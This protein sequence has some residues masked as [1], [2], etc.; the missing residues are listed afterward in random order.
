MPACAGGF[1]SRCS[2]EVGRVGA[3]SEG[4]VL[5][6]ELTDLLMRAWS[7]YAAVR[8]RGKGRFN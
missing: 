6:H 7:N 5:E 1:E 3:G 2:R 8:E 4:E